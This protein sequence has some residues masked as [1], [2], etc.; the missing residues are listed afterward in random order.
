MHKPL[1]I[2]VLIN[3]IKNME[4]TRNTF[5]SAFYH[6]VFST[7][8]RIPFLTGERRV[9]LQQYMVAFIRNNGAQV[10]I[11]NGMPDHMHL[12]VHTSKPSF[13]LPNFMR[14]LKKST[15]QLLNI[16]MGLGGKFQWQSGY[17]AQTLGRSQVQSC[18]SYIRDQELHHTRLSFDDEWE[19]IMEGIL[20][21]E[22]I[23][24]SIQA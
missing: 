1:K 9:R 6:I 16:Q 7:K 8:N 19:K 23:Q 24:N 10:I 11:V 12:L 14:E 3:T 4:A 18:Y 5:Y 22:S 15:N 21:D 17:Y 13:S 2:Y 20:K